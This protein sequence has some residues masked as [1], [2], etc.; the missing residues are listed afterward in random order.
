[1]P[2]KFRV[3][4]QNATLLRKDPFR[5]GVYK[6]LFFFES[7]TF[8]LSMLKN[9]LLR[10]ACKNVHVNIFSLDILLLCC[11]SSIVYILIYPE[12][13][14]IW[15]FLGW[16]NPTGFVTKLICLSYLAWGLGTYFDNPISTNGMLH[17]WENA[18]QPAGDKV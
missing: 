1:M 11:K 15:L 9:V 18:P 16:F 2:M 6:F 17:I 8:F 7:K 12:C 4:E 3:D 14:I 10:K 5:N 13:C